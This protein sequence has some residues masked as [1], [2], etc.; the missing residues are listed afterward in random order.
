MLYF[1]VLRER[2]KSISIITVQQILQMYAFPL[3]Y[4][5]FQILKKEPFVTSVLANRFVLAE[6]ET[7]QTS[8]GTALQAPR[9]WPTRGSS[10]H[11]QTL[12]GASTLQQEVPSPPLPSSAA[13]QS[14]ATSKGNKAKRRS[15]AG[16]GAGPGP[17]AMAC[18]GSSA[19]VVRTMFLGN[20]V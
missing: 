7:K 4:T 19:Q 17:Q 15:Q 18:A 1:A 6:R 20:K 8:A 9:N 12:S 16:G 2:D 5:S 13:A 3:S 11:P 14:Q 10:C